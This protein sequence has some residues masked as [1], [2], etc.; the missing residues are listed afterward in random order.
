MICGEFNKNATYTEKSS[1]SDNL[2]N[3]LFTFVDENRNGKCSLKDVAES[4]SYDY[5]Y[6]SK[7]FKRTVG[8]S[9]CDYVNAYRLGDACYL[10]K[11]TSRPI[12][13]I[14]LEC[15]YTSLR[16]FNRNFKNSFKM[17]PKEYRA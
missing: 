2:L 14:A 6:I 10:L 5:A 8:I 3:L 12:T 11:N 16:S 4:T 7:Y 15:G 17:T 9:F 1:K 13:D